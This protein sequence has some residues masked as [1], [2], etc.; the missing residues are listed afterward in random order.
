MRSF[1]LCTGVSAVSDKELELVKNFC[2]KCFAAHSLVVSVFAGRRSVAPEV[3]GVF[4]CVIACC[5]VNTGVD[6]ASCEPLVDCAVV[7]VLVGKVVP[8]IEGMI[9]VS[10]TPSGFIPRCGDSYP[11]LP[12][13]IQ[14][15]ALEPARL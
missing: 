14:Q 12:L 1:R 10:A 8:D 4:I 2:R 13:I 7:R 15:I 3:P 9:I 6:R 5:I 11:F